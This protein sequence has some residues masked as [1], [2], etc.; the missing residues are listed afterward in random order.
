MNG[1][2]FETERYRASILRLLNVMDATAKRPANAA[3]VREAIL[4]I[5][6]AQELIGLDTTGIDE[7]LARLS[8]IEKQPTP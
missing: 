3:T 1:P 2:K 8:E 7:R 4:A 6:E 5:R